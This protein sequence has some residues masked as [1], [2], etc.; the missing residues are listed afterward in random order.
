MLRLLT[1]DALVVAAARD[2]AYWTWLIPLSG[3]AAFVYDGIFIG[4][5]ATR[6][7]L[8]SSFTASL[9]FFVVLGVA[10]VSPLART[11]PFLVNHILWLAYIVYLAMR[12]TMQY[13]LLR[14]ATTR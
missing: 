4:L 5:T 9:V 7:M 12:G 14:S 1:D 3:F 8:L 11:H 6:G 2:F 10:V 13:F